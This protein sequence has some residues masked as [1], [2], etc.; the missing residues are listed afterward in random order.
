[1]RSSVGLKPQ[2]SFKARKI[3]TSNPGQ[4]I[5]HGQYALPA[6][7]RPHDG[8]GTR[9]G[10]VCDRNLTGIGLNPGGWAGHG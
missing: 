3:D 7:P 4:E 1:M 2:K 9:L 6:R 8:G 10:A 5:G